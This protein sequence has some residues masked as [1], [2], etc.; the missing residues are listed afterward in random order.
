[1][2]AR[3]K[4]RLSMEDALSN[5][6]PK[7]VD[8]FTEFQKAPDA[9]KGESVLEQLNLVF[10]HAQGVQDK[11]GFECAERNA[12]L[13]IDVESA[14]AD[15]EEAQLQ[16]S[17]VTQSLQSLQ[18]GMER[19]EAEI[20]TLRTQF[21][22]HRELCANNTKI[23]SEALKNLT[24]DVTKATTLVTDVTAGCKGGGAPAE[25]VEC[26]MPDDTIVA[27][28]KSAA[29]RAKIVE[30]SGQTERLLSQYLNE[31]LQN[32]ALE[33]GVP[34]ED[35]LGESL[36]A[37]K[38]KHRRVAQR[39]RGAVVLQ[40]TVTI[41]G[42]EIPAHLC[43]AA[44]V[45]TCATFVD[46]MESFLG[47]VLDSVDDLNDRQAT[48]SAHCTESLEDYSQTIR[49]LKDDVG[50]S[51]VA[52]ANGI[53]QKASLV[54]LLH[55][56][57]TQFSD[58]SKEAKEKLGTCADQLQD[59]A[60]TICSSK[61]V[62]NKLKHETKGAKF[63]GACEV[64]EWVAGPC[65]EPCG[66][67]GTQEMTRKIISPQLTEADCPAL[68]MTQVC[69]ERPCPIDGQM[70]RWEEWSPCSRLCGGGTRT[71]RRGVERH[72]QHGGLPTAETLQEEVCNPR[73]CDD[74]CQLGDWT[75][76]SNCSTACGSGHRSRERFVVTE[77][78]GRGTCPSPDDVARRQTI[79]CNETA[80][81][82]PNTT[83]GAFKCAS[84]LDLLLVL[85]GSG[86]VT[87]EGF[88]KVKNFATKL[89]E[90]VALQGETAAVA[91]KLLKRSTRDPGQ[92]RA[93]VV[94]FGGAA[95]TEV[96]ELTA[97]RTALTGAL[98]GLAWPG[99]QATGWATNTA[100]ALAVSRQMLQR[101][102]DNPGADQVIVVIS[103]GS[104]NSGRLAA[105]EVARLKSQGVR[106]M[107]VDVGLGIGK[108]A[109]KQ[110]ASW[111][112]VENLLE[113]ATPTDLDTPAK[114]SDL[115]VKLCPVIEETA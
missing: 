10:K 97:T 56:R 37:V 53:A 41:E 48:E 60:D 5:L 52:L 55:Q 12:T 109:A 35:V 101:Q 43:T 58:M 9:T 79:G 113:V 103:N 95:A 11:V 104:P 13:K 15:V 115:L 85:D 22:E 111:P 25:I 51:G 8:L 14:A 54:S 82:C 68:K 105:T 81:A 45:P 107:F 30:L 63:L 32:T 42:Q 99:A 110:W 67:G 24:A 39:Y 94:A 20:E 64:S 96:S 93:G 33:Q 36:L 46:S 4:A 44:R 65:S 77:A 69:N 86:S 70:G 73:P 102:N 2:R 38:T 71:R 21:A 84:H 100:Q 112:Y 88:T 29:E 27:T 108:R 72:P 90:R 106:L 34:A 26:N 74:D 23:Y 40:G 57:R 75:V 62:W 59:A 76:W 6:P 66:V 17:T 87:T 61:Q 19:S 114:V 16:L 1:M 47:N 3:A 98:G 7:V 91:E 18:N 89:L 80:P 49:R 28:F 83:I 31:A 78:V 50:N 92:A